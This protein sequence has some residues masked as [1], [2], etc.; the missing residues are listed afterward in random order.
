MTEI[1]FGWDAILGLLPG[2]GDVASLAPAAY[3]LAEAHDM[4][5]P[6]SVKG[7]MVFNTGVDLLVGLV[8]LVGDLFDVGV[9]SNNRNVALLRAHFDATE[10]H[11]PEVTV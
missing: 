5:A 9:R 11:V 4:G 6:D 7:R 2:V 3:I 10:R 1:R 8:P